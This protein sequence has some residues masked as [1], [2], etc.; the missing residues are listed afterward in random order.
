MHV[1]LW[2]LKAWFRVIVSF[3]H[4]DSCCESLR[5]PSETKLS[6]FQL[7]GLISACMLSSRHCTFGASLYFIFLARWGKLRTPILPIASVLEPLSECVPMGVPVSVCV[8]LMFNIHP[9]MFFLVHCMLWFI[10]DMLL[11][12]TVQ[13]CSMGGAEY[14]TIATASQQMNGLDFKLISWTQSYNDLLVSAKY[15][16]FGGFFWSRKAFVL[17][18]FRF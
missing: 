12:Y 7:E 18:H 6:T 5:L 11:M 14:V 3:A 15:Q 1:I 17:L 2:R 4:L 13:V 8:W 10:F 16:P 9:V